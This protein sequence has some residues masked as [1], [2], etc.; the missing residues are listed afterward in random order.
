MV[1]SLVLK[2]SQVFQ[3]TPL[4]AEKSVPNSWH[5]VTH[6]YGISFPTADDR[7]DNL[8]RGA[9]RAE[10]ALLTGSRGNS[11]GNVRAEGALP[12]R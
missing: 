11:Q 8:D 1:I 5:N 7:R 6:V 3:H 12:T 4:V 10:G 9:V 2:H